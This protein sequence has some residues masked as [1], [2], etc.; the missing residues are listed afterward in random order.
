M[1]RKVMLALFGKAFG[2]WAHGA[3]EGKNGET[4]KDLYWSLAGKKTII[5]AVLLVA[6]AT[7]AAMGKP[8]AAEVVVT[9]AGI[10]V[11]AGLIDK[12]W[13]S[14]RPWE[15]LPAWTLLR[16]HSADV[17]AVL[18]LVAG[19]FTTCNTSTADILAKVH[20]TCH[21]GIAVITT[22]TAVFTWAIAEAKTALPPKAA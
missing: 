18:G 3:A 13:R 7:L 11:G 14:D 17:L 21:T 12:A 5:G 19:Y 4:M 15:S 20:L 10:L 22:V 9:L 2:S 6:S 16:N 8:D 1:L